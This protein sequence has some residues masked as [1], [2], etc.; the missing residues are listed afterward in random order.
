MTSSTCLYL[1]WPKALCDSTKIWSTGGKEGVFLHMPEEVR[2][3]IGKPSAGN[4]MGHG[5]GWNREEMRWVDWT[6]PRP[7][8]PAWKNTDLCWRYHGHGPSC[9]KAAAGAYSRTSRQM[10][11]YPEKTSSSRKSSMGCSESHASRTALPCRDLGRAGLQVIISLPVHSSC[12]HKCI[13]KQNN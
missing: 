12:L 11:H 1:L 10:S 4:G 6:L 2:K 8:S 3:P 5:G 7:R 9:P 13:I